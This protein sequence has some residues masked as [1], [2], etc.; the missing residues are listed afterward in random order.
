MPK[1]ILVHD[2]R[3]CQCQTGRVQVVAAP[4][5]A[6][7]FGVAATVKEED[8]YLVLSAEPTLKA[9]TES[10]PHLLIRA[11]STLPKPAGSVVVQRGRPLRLLAIVHNLDCEP[12]WREEWVAAALDGVLAITAERHL[13]SLRLPV[14]AARHGHLRPQRFIALL[15]TAL[16]HAAPE[17]P[18]LIWLE[19][20]AGVSCAL[21]DGLRE[22]ALPEDPGM[23]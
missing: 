9:P 6:P 19:L 10:L 17:Y 13:E 8:T 20:P 21:L 4:R 14:L 18:R 2:R 7:P 23:A 15:S 22:S 3:R 1:P 16:R 11:L 5:W 12:T